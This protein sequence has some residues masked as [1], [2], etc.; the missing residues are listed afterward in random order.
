MVRRRQ[1]T[2]R[3]VIVAAEGSFH[4]RTAA[5]LALTG[6]SSI[7]EPFAPFGFDVRFVPFGDTQALRAAVR[8]DCAA[9]FLESP[10]R[11]RRGA[12]SRRPAGYLAAARE[13]CDYAAARCS[14]S[15]RSRAGSAG[16][17]RGSPTSRAGVRLPDVMTL[18][19]GLG[20][21]VPIGACIGLGDCGTALL[22]RVTTGSTFGGE[23]DCLRGGALA[24]LDT[25]EADG[26]LGQAAAIGQLARHR[27]PPRV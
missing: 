20:G 5:A 1:G 24:V 2:G 26:L 6:Q 10:A 17:G 19:K 8:P 15:M 23:P 7:R 18:A 11:A 13:A 12:G 27:D 14:S 3:S 4:G 25:I 9:V 16:P 22:A 21:G